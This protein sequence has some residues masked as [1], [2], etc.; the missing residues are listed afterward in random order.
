MH[1]MSAP[2]NIIVLFK[3]FYLSVIE[4]NNVTIQLS[5]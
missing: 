1:V 4:K 5:V 2:K 3:M